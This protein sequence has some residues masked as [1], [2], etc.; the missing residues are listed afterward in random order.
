MN[1]GGLRPFLP[2]FLAEKPATELRSTRNMRNN[3]RRRNS[4]A[5]FPGVL[6]HEIEVVRSRQDAFP[7]RHCSAHAS[8]EGRRRNILLIDALRGLLSHNVT[9]DRVRERNGRSRTPLTTLN[10]AVSPNASASVSTATAVKRVLQQL[11]KANLRSFI[12]RCQ[13]SGVRSQWSLSVAGQI[14]KP[15]PK[16]QRIQAA[17]PTDASL[18]PYWSLE[19]GASLDLGFGLWSFRSYPAPPTFDVQRSMFDVRCSFYS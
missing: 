13:W 18:P 1:H 10:S 17:N 16:R 19:F 14:P 15:Q 11:G 12:V 6:R 5:L 3:S 8:R 9:N 2:I 7:R 4:P